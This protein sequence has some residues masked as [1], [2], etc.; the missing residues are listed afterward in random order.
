M[1]NRIINRLR[2]K[3]KEARAMRVFTFPGA[4]LTE[5]GVAKATT[6]AKRMDSGRGTS[7]IRFVGTYGKDGNCTILL[8]YSK[9]PASETMLALSFICR[10]QE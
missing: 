1:E 6:D 8:I 5:S 3:E 7:K 4:I 9:S 2:A 10:A